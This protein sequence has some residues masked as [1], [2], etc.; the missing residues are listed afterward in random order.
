MGPTGRPEMWVTS[1]LYSLRNDPEEHISHLL[2][3]GS[4]K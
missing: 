1:Y 2:R 4:L 3:G